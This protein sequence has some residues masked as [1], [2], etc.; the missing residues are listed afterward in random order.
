MK[1]TIERK[2]LLSALEFICGL[3]K[4][5]IP[6]QILN[7][8]LLIVDEET[9]TLISSD[10]EIEIICIIKQPFGEPGEI[11]VSGRK[12]LDICRALPEDSNINVSFEQDQLNVVSG[13]SRFALMTLP[14]KDFPLKDD[15]EE[16]QKIQLPQS[17]LRN[18]LEDTM[19]AMAQDDV[20]Y[21]LNGLLLEVA[22]NGGIRAVA[23]DGHRLAL[24]EAYQNEDNESDFSKADQIILP[25]K[26][27]VELK[28]LLTGGGDNE[29][30]TIEVNQK[31]FRFMK[32][33]LRLT[34]KLVDG[35]FPDYQRVIPGKEDFPVT[36]DKT[37]LRQL[38]IRS[39]ILSN[40][41]NRTVRLVLDNNLLKAFSHNIG[42]EKAE[43]EIK[44][45]YGGE[46]IEIG[47]NVTYLLD[48][49]SGIRTEEVVLHISDSNSSCL[50]LPHDETECK[51]VVMPTRL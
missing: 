3:I 37:I 26:T 25:R 46:K 36:I 35:K 4:Q 50:I 21:Y 7:N 18:L 19:L 24:K 44:V 39:S 33:N 13:R 48:A 29:T 45:N 31:Q 1:F 23:T 11:T 38:L 49:L 20:R 47:F 6:I 51:H 41:K 14:A 2:T 27:V 15:L 8:I 34:S 9:I 5:S 43:E 22:S 40:E 28:R 32:D 30:V 12:L 17:H 42:E 10:T 16:S